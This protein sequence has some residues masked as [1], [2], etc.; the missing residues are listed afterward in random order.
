[1]NQEFIFACPQCKGVLKQVDPDHLTCM[2]D[3]LDFE[4]Q[5]G[6]WRFILPERRSHYIQF[7][8]EYETVRKG[9]ARGASSNAPART[10]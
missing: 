10:P 5:D 8:G 3:G 7:I 6:I 4:R 1:M 2:A 9:E